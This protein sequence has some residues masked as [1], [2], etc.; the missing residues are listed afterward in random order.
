MIFILTWFVPHTFELI[1]LWLISQS[2]FLCEHMF[3]R[4]GALSRIKV[5]NY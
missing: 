4:P 3:S 5:L 2:F 1:R